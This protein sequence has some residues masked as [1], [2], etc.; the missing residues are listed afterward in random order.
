MDNGFAP[1]GNMF[2]STPV[3]PRVPLHNDAEA[4]ES[5]LAVIRAE[6][7][8]IKEIL[9][10]MGINGASENA[11]IESDDISSSVARSAQAT[12][13]ILEELRWIK[14]GLR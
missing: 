14:E 2:M 11:G 8:T 3:A 9:F 4:I 13:R 7:F 5:N 12:N 6:I 10:G 1:T